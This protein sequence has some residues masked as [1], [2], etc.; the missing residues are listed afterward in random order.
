MKICDVFSAGKRCISFEFFPP[1]T[2]Q[3]MDS[4]F[5]AIERLKCYRP[6]YVS[7]TYGAGGSTRDKTMEM[8][9]RI[10]EETGLEVMCHVTCVAQAKEEVHGVL[11]RLKLGGIEN[12]LALGGDPPK[13]WDNF[14]PAEGGF[15][16][17]AALI[18]YIRRNFSFGIAAA[19]FP[20][21]HPE[22]PDLESDTAHLKEKV[23]AGAEFVVTQL[24]YDNRDYFEFMERFEKSGMR[25]PVVAGVLPILNTAQVR[26]FTALCGAKIPPELD[27]QLEKYAEDDEGARELGVEY[28]T[29]QV[30]EL[31]RSGVAGIHF[32]TLNRSYSASKI[33]DSLASL[34]GSRLT[35]A[36]Q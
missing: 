24:F 9:T 22:A 13:E 30:E 10:K 32:Y 12:V 15:H 19:C 29:R 26:R 3:G 18:P 2:D 21:G 28:A 35:I 14:A 23:D 20:E 11:D 1:R 31:W 17:A 36:S 27:R 4:L 6:D 33:L 16:G 7:V 5:R 8:V 25:V 34:L